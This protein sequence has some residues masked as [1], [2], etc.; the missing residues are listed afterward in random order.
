MQIGNW[1]QCRKFCKEENI[2]SRSVLN[3]RVLIY[4][5]FST[6]KF[7]T[8]FRKLTLLEYVNTLL[9]SV[10]KTFFA[11]NSVTWDPAMLENVADHLLIGQRTFPARR[12]SFIS[13]I[14]MHKFGI[15]RI[16]TL[17]HQLCHPILSGAMLITFLDSSRLEE[18]KADKK[19][20]ARN[21]A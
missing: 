14:L 7:D 2:S 15:I 20:F 16:R 10:I 3:E 8:H 12:V 4:S 1:N 21:K 17:Q 19:I 5:D 18:M 6:S 11:I 9:F 13:E